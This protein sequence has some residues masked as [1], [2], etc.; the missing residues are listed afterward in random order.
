M[1]PFNAQATLY[2]KD[3]FWGLL[4]PISVHGRVSD[5]LRSFLVQRLLWE[6]GR[7]LT[8]SQPFVKQVRNAHKYLADFVAEEPLYTKSGELIRFLRDWQAPG[9]PLADKMLALTSKMFQLGIVEKEDVFLIQSWIDDLNA[10]QYAW[11]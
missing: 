3:A 7:T 4:L 10:L 11:P 8:F 2:H 1:A 5:I 6:T 9:G